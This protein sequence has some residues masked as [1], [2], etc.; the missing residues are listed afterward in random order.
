MTKEKQQQMLLVAMVT[1]IVLCGI[2]FGLI[3]AQK[4]NLEAANKKTAEAKAKIENA[5]RTLKREQAIEQELEANHK[6]LTTREESMASGDLYQWFLTRMIS[7]TSSRPTSNFYSDPP[8][9]E[10]VKLLPKFPYRSANY[11]VRISGFYHEVG[12][13]LADIE[14]EW[15]YARIQNMDI[16]AGP[17][18]EEKLNF[19]FELSTL[20]HTNRTVSLK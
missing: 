10:D 3:S 19:T 5:Q 11:K 6:E 18:G 16:S 4:K 7:A 17:A 20:Y 1:V 13:F 14:N 12:K 15:P 9:L 2:W 8:V